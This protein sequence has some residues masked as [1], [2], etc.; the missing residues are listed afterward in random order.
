MTAFGWLALVPLI[1]RVVFPWLSS[2]WRHVHQTSMTAVR[3]RLQLDREDAAPPI[4]KHSGFTVRG[5]GGYRAAHPGRHGDSRS[6][7]AARARHWPRLH[8][9]Q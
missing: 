9:S 5:D 8:Q 1:L 6:P 2:R 3:T 7:L 4:G